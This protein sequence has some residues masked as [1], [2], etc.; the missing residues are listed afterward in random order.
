MYEKGDS[1]LV[2]DMVCGAELLDMH[3]VLSKH[4]VSKCG[5]QE[6]TALGIS[7]ERSP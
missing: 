7:S 3:C 6:R 5:T 1:A 4:P 2:L